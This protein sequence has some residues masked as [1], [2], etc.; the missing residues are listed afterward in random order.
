MFSNTAMTVESA[1][2]DM[3]TKN[4]EPQSRPNGMLLKMLGRVTNTRPGPEP[5]FTPKAKQAG[6]MMSPAMSA[7]MVSSRTMY[8]A[9]P[10]RERD[11][12]M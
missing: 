9:S 8:R 6:K 1:A 2:K 3:N 10:V 4:S 5:G 11:L 7:T 12:P